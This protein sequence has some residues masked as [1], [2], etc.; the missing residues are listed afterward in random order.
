MK[1]EEFTKWAKEEY[2][3]TR[4]EFPP[5]SKD[6]EDFF[7]AAKKD[8]DKFEERWSERPPGPDDPS[9]LDDWYEQLLL[10]DLER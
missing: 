7:E 4:S 6:A 5:E 3:K 1:V 2:D 10:S 8:I 9:S